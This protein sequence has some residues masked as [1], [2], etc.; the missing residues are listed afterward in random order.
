MDDCT[1]AFHTAHIYKV[2]K[3]LKVRRMCLQAISII[4]LACCPILAMNLVSFLSI[5][6]PFGGEYK[7]GQLYGI[8]LL[9]GISRNGIASASAFAATALRFL[10]FCLT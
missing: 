8:T 10:H 1:L 5:I 4:A 6:S 2:L 7:R 3:V 9:C